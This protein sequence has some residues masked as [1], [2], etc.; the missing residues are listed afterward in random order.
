MFGYGRRA[1]LFPVVVVDSPSREV[2]DLV[3][4]GALLGGGGFPFSFLPVIRWLF[5]ATKA[6][7]QAWDP[8]R[9]LVSCS[10][11]D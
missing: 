5:V 9:W 11:G 6:R 8:G 7:R 2:V 10:R 4:A 3:P 1:R